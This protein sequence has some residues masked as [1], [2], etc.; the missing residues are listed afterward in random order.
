MMAPLRAWVAHLVVSAGLDKT[1]GRCLVFA[2]DLLGLLLA[3]KTHHH[4]ADFIEDKD[5]DGERN[6]VEPHEV[7]ESRSLEGGVTERHVRE[8]ETEEGLLKEANIESEIGHALLKDGEGSGLANHDIGP[9]NND[10]GHE[11]G[12]LSLAEVAHAGVVIETTDECL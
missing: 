1:D 9:L 5:E 10:D 7:I 12:G 4:L 11:E 8:G 6:G 2:F 3:L